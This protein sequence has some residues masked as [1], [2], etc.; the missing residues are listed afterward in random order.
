M[1]SVGRRGRVVRFGIGLPTVLIGQR[2][3]PTGRERFGT[4]LRRGDL[5]DVEIE[6]RRQV[7]AGADI[8]DVNVG[9]AGIDEP[10]TLLAAV[11]LVT[12][13]TE[14]PICIDSA[15]PAALVAAL[16][17]YD[18]KALVNSVTAARA[19]MEAILPAVAAHGAAVIALPIDEHGVP[20]DARARLANAARICEAAA[21]AGIPPDDVV[22]D[23]LTVPAGT[24]PEAAARALETLRLVQSELGVSTTAGVSDIS[25]GLSERR[26]VDLAFLA[27]AVGT[28][29]SA[30][31][32][33]VTAPGLRRLCR[34]CDVLAGRDA[35]GRRY[36]AE[37]R[38]DPSS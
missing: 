12:R 17:A 18:G 5:T 2:I 9:V 16:D 31:I 11:E 33:D 7:D 6:A 35:G 10:A 36:V 3:N 20:S 14:V 21:R 30:P 27:M 28:G 15:D 8:L 26:V 22:V 24:E 38:R 29:L 4:A 37:L 23:V 32:A 34:A 1:T 25:F 19:S 13:C